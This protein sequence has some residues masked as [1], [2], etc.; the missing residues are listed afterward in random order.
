M[1][2]KK[3]S[4]S[5]ANLASEV[6]ELR[7][8][9]AEARET[10]E[11]IRT[12]AVDALVVSGPNGNLVFS[13]EGAE[14]PYR[15]LVEEI[16]E[17]ALLLRPDG[18]IL[19]ANARFAQ[20]TNTPLDQVIGSSCL[21]FFPLERCQLQ[22][23]MQAA[24]QGGLRRECSLQARGGESRP[25][26]V[27]LAVVHGKP[28]ETLSAI[29]SDLTERKAAEDA[30]RRANTKLQEAVGELEHFSYT[31]TH[32]MRAPLRAMRGL[33]SILL[34]ECST[35]SHGTRRDYLRRIADSAE[36]MDKLITDALQYSGVVRQQ[37]HLE[38]VDTGALLR[39]ILESY[40]QFQPPHADIRIDG[41]LPSVVGNQAILTQCFS[42]L[43]GNAIKFV[44][45][46]RPPEVRVWA[47]LAH[48]APSKVRLWFEDK[49]IGI[50]EQYHDKIWQMFQQLNKSYEGTGIGLALV[51]KAVERMG[52]TVGVES[53]L[54]KGSR[55]WV[56]LKRADAEPQPKRTCA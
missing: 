33:G 35:C 32:D 25:V 50:E 34:E 19:Y 47:E 24:R 43:L 53:E 21:R 7:T 9:L 36:R 20:L 37:L 26:E 48:S 31:I 5:A 29:V 42:N 38:P 49:G 23:L 22:P 52:G 6:A 17:G 56:E 15:S 12:G 27:S 39:G 3:K 4:A 16:N 11:A 8:Q 40:P 1:R 54:G 46:G 30:L 2:R 44:H 18:T 51:H 55:F 13:L 45:P 10:L 28:T 14:T 41:P